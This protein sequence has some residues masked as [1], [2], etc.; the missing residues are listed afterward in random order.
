MSQGPRAPL[1]LTVVVPQSARV[2]ERVPIVLRLTNASDHPVDAHFLG[3]TIVFDIVV[4]REDGTVVWRRLEGKVTQG[5]LQLRT[6]QPRQTMEWRDTWR[7]RARGVYVIRGELP[8]D[9]PLPRRSSET[10][11][12]IE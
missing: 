7:P 9:N 2:G 3:R 5:I 6:L 10:R 11:I 12:H 4:S 8:S 1:E